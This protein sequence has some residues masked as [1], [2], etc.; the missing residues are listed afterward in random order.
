LGKYCFV[1]QTHFKFHSNIFLI[2]FLSIRYS[3]ERKKIM[4]DSKE[5]VESILSLA[6]VLLP[7]ITNYPLLAPTESHPIKSPQV[8]EPSLREVEMKIQKLTKSFEDLGKPKPKQLLEV[9]GLFFLFFFFFQKLN[10][11]TRRVLI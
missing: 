6:A 10:K 1:V 3:D 4:F 8:I 7:F 5:N 11:K 2:F 9:K